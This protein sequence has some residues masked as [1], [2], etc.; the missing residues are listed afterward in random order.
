MP[1][2]FNPFR[3]RQPGVQRPQDHQT[4]QETSQEPVMTPE[5]F[6]RT[7]DRLER[8]AVALRDAAAKWRADPHGDA[9]TAR[10]RAHL[11]VVHPIV[12][13]ASA[14]RP[15]AGQRDIINGE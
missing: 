1:K 8:A 14:L 13:A 7:A 9:A 5:L 11:A 12:T 3:Q 10:A 2:H 15:F 4:A 6:E